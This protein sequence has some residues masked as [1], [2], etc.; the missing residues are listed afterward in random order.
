MANAAHRLERAVREYARDND[1][2]FPGN[3][4]GPNMAGKT[5]LDYLPSGQMLI[6]AFTNTRTEPSSYFADYSGAIGYNV[7]VAETVNVGY[8]ISAM[9]IDSDEILILAFEPA[10]GKINEHP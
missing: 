6:N 1:G 7:Y 9:G 8:V 4:D 3:L 5:L 10:F 2:I